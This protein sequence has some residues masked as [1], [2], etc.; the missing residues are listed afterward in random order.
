MKFHY[1][2]IDRLKIKFRELEQAQS[3]KS[4]QETNQSSRKAP[5]R[6]RNTS[7][8]KNE[9]ELAEVLKA[10]IREVDTLLE[11]MRA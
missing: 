11:Q 9:N 5:A 7:K 2:C 4:F 10:K 6:N 8:D 1:R 3:H